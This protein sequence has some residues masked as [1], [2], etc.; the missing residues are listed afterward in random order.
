MMA[1]PSPAGPALKTKVSIA[2]P[3][4]QTKQT[5]KVEKVV[6]D[7]TSSY[8]APNYNVILLGDEEY[9]KGH[10]VQCLMDII[11]G[12]D[13]KRADNAYEA[14]MTSRAALVAVAPKEVAEHYAKELARC[15][16]IVYADIEPE[17]KDDKK[18]K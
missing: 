17:N 10:V 13:K 12:M 9:S 3:S 6:K 1:S 5:V 7:K 4:L 11:E 16:P 14:C 18:G 8:M 15:D 2:K